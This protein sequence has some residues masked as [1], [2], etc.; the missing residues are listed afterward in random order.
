MTYLLRIAVVV[1]QDRLDGGFAS[2]HV[3]MDFLQGEPFENWTTNAGHL[4]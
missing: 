2:G 4:A 1:R 3:S